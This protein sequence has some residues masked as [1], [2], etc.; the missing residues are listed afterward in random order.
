MFAGMGKMFQDEGNEVTREDFGQ[1]YSL[2]AFNLTATF[3]TAPTL[4][5]YKKET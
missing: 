5:W 1:G 4:N 2:F 3:A